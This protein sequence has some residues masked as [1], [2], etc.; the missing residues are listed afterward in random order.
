MARTKN[1]PRTQTQTQDM[2]LLGSQVQGI[3][4]Q[5]KQTKLDR[6]VFPRKK[7]PLTKQKA[8]RARRYRPGTVALRE[9]RKFQKSTDLLIQKAPFRRLVKEI[10][11]NIDNLKRFQTTAVD[12]L[13]EASEHYLVNLLEEANVCAI[14]A[15]RVTIMP[16]DMRLA[17]KIRGDY[18]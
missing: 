14:H 5:K 4:L 18:F 10:A 15:K 9:I 6:A 3:R 8:I 13:Q 11:L 12:A 17:R 1:T 7:L 16:K 2:Q